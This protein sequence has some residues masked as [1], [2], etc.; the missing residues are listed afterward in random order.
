MP[1]GSKKSGKGGRMRKEKDREV[2]ALDEAILEEEEEAILEEEEVVFEDEAAKEGA[3]EPV[4]G[5]VS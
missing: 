5:E 3:K 2:E 4:R 1:E